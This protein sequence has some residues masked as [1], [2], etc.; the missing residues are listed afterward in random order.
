[1]KKKKSVL[2]GIQEFFSKDANGTSNKSNSALHVLCGSVVRLPDKI[3]DAQLNL[4]FS[5]TTDIFSCVMQHV[6]CIC[7]KQ[8]F[9][10]MAKFRN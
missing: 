5:K 6:G 8:L 4:N 9:E 10:N 2:H 3:Q 1:M 7:F